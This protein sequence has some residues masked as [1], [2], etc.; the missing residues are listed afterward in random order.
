MILLGIQ[1]ASPI[2]NK[3]DLYFALICDDF[4][5]E[6]IFL[7]KQVLD[8]SCKDPNPLR[9][10]IE[11]LGLCTVEQIEQAAKLNLALSFFVAHLYFY[12]KTYTEH[13]FGPE[14]TNRWTPLSAATKVG[15]RWSIHQDHATFPG[16][17]LPFANI[18][19]AVTR[20]QRD[21]KSKVYGPEYRVT[22]HEAMKAVTID[23]A[24][25][26]H[27]DDCLGSLKEGKKADL[28]IVSDNPFK[29]ITLLRKLECL[30]SHIHIAKDEI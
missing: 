4:K 10:R 28:I 23:A 19:T 30:S 9:H 18:K 20:T 16:P 21:D 17:P 24:W 3:V 14:R 7:L 27:K 25:Q 1:L 2:A 15:L 29:V 12:G 26:L 22:I 11:H 13:I 5:I 6:V 8:K